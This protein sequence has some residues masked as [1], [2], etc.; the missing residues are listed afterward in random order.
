MYTFSKFVLELLKSIML[1]RN[2]ED[3]TMK[4]HVHQT[5]KMYY[6]HKRAASEKK[7]LQAL[8]QIMEYESTIFDKLDIFC[9]IAYYT[10]ALHIAIWQ[11]HI[12]L[13]YY[14]KFFWE[15]DGIVH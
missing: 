5:N 6:Y 10:I 11:W 8:N 3:C 15:K 1:K 13:L 4:I 12:Y 14:K 2:L 9:N 7:S